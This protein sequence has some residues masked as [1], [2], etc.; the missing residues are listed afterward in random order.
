M[1]LQAN[2]FTI[3]FDRM[4]MFAEF[5]ISN[6]TFVV[7]KRNLRLEFYDFAIILNRFIKVAE[8]RIDNPPAKIAIYILRV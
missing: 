6:P 8:F 7:A 2:G 5:I 4:L 3:V 1:R